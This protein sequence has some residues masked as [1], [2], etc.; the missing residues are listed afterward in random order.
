MRDFFHFK[1]SPCIAQIELPGDFWKGKQ[2]ISH[3][4]HHRE[5]LLLGFANT[6]GFAVKRWNSA[7]YKREKTRLLA[8]E[9]CP[10]S[11]TYQSEF[12]G[13]GR[14][15][16][17]CSNDR[18]KWKGL[19]AAKST[20][21]AVQV[22]L[23]ARVVSFSLTEHKNQG[24]CKYFHKIWNWVS[25]SEQLW[26]NSKFLFFTAHQLP[27]DLSWETPRAQ[28]LKLKEKKTASL[29][30]STGIF[31]E[32]YLMSS[33]KWRFMICSRN[34]RFCGSSERSKIGGRD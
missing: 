17:H 29:E 22:A 33:E 7:I 13:R 9:D 2:A 31:S 30:N 25:C 3:F 24:L 12:G 11:Y 20:F 15:D 23:T 32:P 4:V 1:T 16:D 6:S 34:V 28:K 26:P 5:Y 21:Y 8:E 14:G 19:T 18:W 10:G 27:R